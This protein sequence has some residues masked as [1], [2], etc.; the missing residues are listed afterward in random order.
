MMNDL[1]NFIEQ[2][3]S[4][5]T[6]GEAS[7]KSDVIEYENGYEVLSDI[8]GVS[9]EMIKISFDESTLN[10]EVSKK[11]DGGN[12]DYKLCERNHAFAK[13]TIYFDNEI[14]S[15]KAEAKYENGVL[16]IYLPKKPKKTTEIKID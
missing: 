12:A 8:P 1:N 10:I 16:T 4:C 7:I 9:K 15:E 6:K 11:E 3:N 5:F 13:K 2:L 14:D